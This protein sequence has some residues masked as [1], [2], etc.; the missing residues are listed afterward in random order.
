MNR[1]IFSSLTFLALAST[2]AFA[3][4]LMAGQM[5]PAPAP[6]H[7]PKQAIVSLAVEPAKVELHSKYGYAQLL[8]TAKLADGTTADV[9]RL[10]KF[11]PPVEAAISPAGQ[12]TPLKNGTGS[13]TVQVGGQSA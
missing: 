12:L 9:T 8:V 5:A 4:A 13:L 1:F 6:E 2:P 3:N 10:A 7:L 11:V